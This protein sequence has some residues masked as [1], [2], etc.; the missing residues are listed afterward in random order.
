[1][2]VIAFIRSTARKSRLSGALEHS[3]CVLFAV[4]AFFLCKFF[5]SIL[6]REKNSLDVRT[7]DFKIEEEGRKY[8]FQRKKAYIRG[9]TKT[10]E[11]RV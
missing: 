4:Y 10:R 8:T 7:E 9:E 11:E 5:F 2:P 3:G 6:S 1:M